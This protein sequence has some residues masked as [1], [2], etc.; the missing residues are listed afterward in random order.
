MWTANFSVDFKVRSQVSKTPFSGLMIRPWFFPSLIFFQL[1]QQ[2]DYGCPVPRKPC[3]LIV[4]CN[5]WEQFSSFYSNI[6]WLFHSSGCTFTHYQNA[7]VPSYVI[8]N[9]W[10]C[11]H[12]IWCVTLLPPVSLMLQNVLWSHNKKIVSF[13]LSDIMW[14][15]RNV[16]YEASWVFP[17]ESISPASPQLSKGWAWLLYLQLMIPLR[18][19]PLTL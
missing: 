6:P 3:F 15:R 11:D 12:E 9:T 18:M 2:L 19:I 8:C 4:G 5:S 13:C 7:S 10:T 14:G 17:Q 1:L 16:A